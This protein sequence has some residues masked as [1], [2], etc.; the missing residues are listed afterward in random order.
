LLPPTIVATAANCRR[1]NKSVMPAIGAVDPADLDAKAHAELGFLQWLE[2][3]LTA[4][5]FWWQQQLS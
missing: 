3:R 1:I 4:T 2:P 5:L